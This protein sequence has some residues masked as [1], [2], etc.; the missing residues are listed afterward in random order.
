MY[1]LNLSPRAILAF[2]VAFIVGFLLV[3]AIMPSKRGFPEV[4]PEL[5]MEKLNAEVP[6]SYEQKTNG[7][8]YEPT[9]VDMGPPSGTESNIRVN[10]Y[11]AFVQ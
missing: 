7:T 4:K 3:R 8:Q 1:K 6:S 2:I 9:P 11:T 5:V 10:A